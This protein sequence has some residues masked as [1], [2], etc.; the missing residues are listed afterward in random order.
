VTPAALT[1]TSRPVTPASSARLRFFPNDSDV[2][3]ND[4]PQKVSAT[5]DGLSL[6]IP[7]VEQKPGKTVAKLDGVLSF[8]DA[9]TGDA[10]TT[11]AILISARSVQPRRRP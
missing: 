8:H 4:K 3:D 2:V 7:R 6:T 1:L 9:S 5:K 11:R 10:G